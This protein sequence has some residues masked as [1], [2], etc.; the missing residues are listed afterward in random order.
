MNIN[1]TKSP[2][3]FFYTDN[4]ERQALEPIAQEAR[5][6][7]YETVYSMNSREYA[8]IGVYCEHACT[9]NAKFSTIMLHDLAQRHDVWPNFWHH[10]PWDRFDLGFLP[11]ESWVDR[12]KS[13]AHYPQSRPRLGI[14]NTGWPKADLVFKDRDMFSKQ[15]ELLRQSLNLKHEK[16]VLYAPSWENNFKQ[17]EFVKAFVDLPVN[18]LLKQAP[19]PTT[20]PDILKNIK[21]M[22]DLHAGLAENIH[23]VDPE[24]SIMY[25]L[26]IADA[27]VSDE[28][29][30]LTE[31]LLLGVPPVAVVDWL[32]PDQNPPRKASVPYDYVI[33]TS[34][35][36]M[37][38]DVINILENPSAVTSK[39]HSDRD[40]Q[41]SNL[42]SSSKIAMDLIE[43]GLANA[44]MGSSQFRFSPLDATVDADRIE[45]QRYVD[46]LA[47]GDSSKAMEILYLLLEKN[48]LCWQVYNDFGN[49]AYKNGNLQDALNM[50]EKAISLSSSS[51]M[52]LSNLIEMYSAINRFDLAHATFIRLCSHL[53]PSDF[54]VN[55]MRLFIKDIN[56]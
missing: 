37:R 31:A 19:W 34:R 2:I 54:I 13:Q 9:P 56:S 45:Y 15:G 38:E 16:T 17:D 7:G 49:L 21:E 51:I 20:Y 12:W 41:F 52:P 46:L 24:I 1:N 8:E 22:N 47:A 42:G 26:G 44:S 36:R 5:N 43:D 29:S 50:F 55:K 48:T 30:V 11:G 40:Q 3:T 33:K 53:P 39:I 14:F 23:I 25:C 28:S 18:L 27:I 32:I 35:V 4:C 6:R 10:E